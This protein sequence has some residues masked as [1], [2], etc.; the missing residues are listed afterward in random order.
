MS[1]IRSGVEQ[2]RERL[3]ALV[4][5]L[6]RA[7]RHGDVTQEEIIRDLKI[8]EY[9]A[10]SKVPFKVPA[11]SGN[12]G[13]VRQKFERDK[14]RIRELGF[15]IETVVRDDGAI[16]YRIDP[17]SG[18]APLIYFTPD[19]AR[20]VQL[21][22]RLTGFGKTGMFSVFN[23]VPAVDGS[24][25]ASSYYT[26]VLRALKLH[27]V[28]IFDYRSKVDKPRMVEPLLISVFGSSTYLIGRVRG[29][30][31]IKGYRFS[32]MTSMPAALPDTFVVDDGTLELARK[33][34]PEFSKAPS[35]I[36]VV[37]ST[38]DNY[39]QLLSRQFPS[40]L[41]AVLK[42]GRVEVGICFDA[43]SEAMRFVLEAAERVRLESPKALRLELAE[44]LKGVNRGHRIAPDTLSFSGAAANDVLGQ[45]L[46]L[47][48]AVYLSEDGL[49]ISE[50]AQRFSMERDNVR[51]VMDRL[52]SLQPMFDSTDSPAD[53]PAHLIKEC[54]DWDDESNDDS[55]YRADFSDLGHGED[56]PSPFMWRDLFE[57]NVALREA[58]RVYTD[59]A[60]LSAID[61]I[62]AVT[63]SFVQVDVSHR[64]DFLDDVRNA[65]QSHQQLKILYTS[66][67]AEEPEVRTIEPTEIKVLN[68]RTYVRAFCTS[69]DAWRTFRIDR[70]NSVMAQSPTTEVRASDPSPDWLTHV[71]EEGNEVVVVLEGRLRWLFEPLPGA[72]WALTK[73]GRHAVKFR[74]VDPS[75]LDHLM[76][77]AGPGATVVTPEFSK[78]G[79]DL[80][81]RIANHL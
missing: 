70:I 39:A 21:A 34:R 36:D 72:K 37:V 41:A 17:S 27:R 73:D 46:Q 1:S 74:V 76:L 61:K 4:L 29:A 33:W 9:P 12:E 67:I 8:D 14:A 60:I 71:G 30:S 66:A 24:L 55:T 13:A 23:E 81:E 25:V 5:L 16:G 57:L 28:L 11:Y 79:H 62:E 50:L 43:P 52:V 38:N 47:L 15:E 45:T 63:S 44:W 49:R 32:R 64:D 48:H 51:L 19:E 18:Y 58:S 31:E 6:Q 78:A 80:A 3:V 59:R 10:S 2:S 7:W 77:K 35:P 42:D 65:V 69:R 22:L 68:G 56:E 53:F 40:S 26:P 75:F 20:V 54:D